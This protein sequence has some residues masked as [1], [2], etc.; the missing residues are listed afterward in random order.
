MDLSIAEQNQTN[1]WVL[2]FCRAV[3]EH[4]DVVRAACELEGHRVTLA[5]VQRSV[6]AAFFAAVAAV[7]PIDVV[8]DVRACESQRAS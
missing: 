1:T 3:V 6:A 2:T 7:R 4:D 8:V 5:A